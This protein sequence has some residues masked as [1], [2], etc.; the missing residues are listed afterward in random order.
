MCFAAY[1]TCTPLLNVHTN[2]CSSHF[3][4]GDSEA[5][6]SVGRVAS[7]SGVALGR[8]GSRAARCASGARDHEVLRPQV[9]VRLVWPSCRPR[10][11]I[12]APLA[13]EP[14]CPRATPPLFGAEAA[15][16]AAPPRQCRD[17]LPLLCS[18]YFYVFRLSSTCSLLLP[19]HTVANSVGQVT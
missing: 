19:I 13:R 1:F 12:Q 8:R 18:V 3:S 2:G 15:P 10:A 7:S 4:N 14:P 9:E 5:G 11:Y 16:R 17:T 6:P